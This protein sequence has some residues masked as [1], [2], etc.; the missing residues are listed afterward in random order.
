[1]T[2]N[3]LKVDPTQTITLRRG[4][5]RYLRRVFRE[6]YADIQ[7]LIIDQEAFG[8]VLDSHLG[9]VENADQRWRFKNQTEKVEAFDT[10]LKEQIRQR[11]LSDK[12]A[13]Q[14]RRFVER[15]FKKGASRAFNDTSRF[16]REEAKARIRG[17]GFD[18]GRREEFL[19]VS[20]GR[21]TAIEKLHSLQS[22]TLS[23]L[24][25]MTEDMRTK[26]KR[27]L[28]DGLVSGLSPRGIAQ[29]LRDQ[30]DIS[31]HRAE[32][33]AYTELVRA[34]AEGQLESLEQLGVEKVGVA[35][36]WD[37]LGNACSLCNP[38]DGV[39]LKVS[40]AKGMLP[41]HPRCRCAFKIANVGE[42]ADE[43]KSQKRGKYKVT[44]AIEQSQKREEKQ[45]DKGTDWGP[46]KTI[47]KKRPVMNV[48]HLTEE[49]RCMEAFEILLGN[50]NG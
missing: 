38:L 44:K 35:V 48:S 15:G 42:D 27:V 23:D 41:R 26:T 10:W 46:N 49:C 2:S 11:L 50:V 24:R 28:L 21:A 4:F 18:E 30:L 37:A 29:R 12:E 36:E 43:R 1:M 14:W 6:L 19:R 47:S 32:T 31:K 17:Y 3:P 13:D 20:M 5:S 7:D 33:I 39:V 40:E 34:H 22:R 8:L 16:K 25:G 9:Y 45:R